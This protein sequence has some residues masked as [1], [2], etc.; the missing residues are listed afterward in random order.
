MQTSDYIAIISI[1]VTVLI[2]MIGSIYKIITNTNRFEIA[3]HYT[4]E[5][6][7]I[8]KQY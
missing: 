3:E 6:I 5:L 4:K 2:S 7:G 8:Q 1:L